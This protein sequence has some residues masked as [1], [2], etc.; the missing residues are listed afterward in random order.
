MRVAYVC[1]Y[2]RV[3]RKAVGKGKKK[4]SYRGGAIMTVVNKL[5]N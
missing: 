3:L 5:I 1:V 2:R 4:F